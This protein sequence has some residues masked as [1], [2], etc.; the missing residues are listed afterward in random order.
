MKK[1]KEL[2]QALALCFAIY[3]VCFLF[4]LALTLTGGWLDLMANPYLWEC[5]WY[6]GCILSRHSMAL[7]INNSKW[8]FIVFSNAIMALFL[9]LYLRAKGQQV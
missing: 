1:Y 2:V 5:D 6:W 7:A 3:A 4:C 8:G 9:N